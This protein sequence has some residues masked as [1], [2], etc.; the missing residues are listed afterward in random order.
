MKQF[1]ASLLLLTFLGSQ[2]MA[3]GKAIHIENLDWSF[4]GITGTYDREALQ[5]GFQVYR[6]LCA[7][8]HSMDLVAYRNLSA[9]GYSEDQ[10]K[11]IAAEDLIIDGPD[12][13]GEMFE[14]PGRPSDYFRNPY[15]NDNQ[16][17]YANNGALPPDLSL[18]AKARKGGPDYIY[19]LLTGYEETPADKKMNPGMHYNVSFSG[20]QI[21]MANPLSESILAYADPDTPQTIEQYAYD[22]AHFLQWT[23]EPSLEAQ[24]RVGI[25]VVLFLLALSIVMYFVKKRLWAKIKE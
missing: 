23:S 15:A 17:R 3:A 8:C 7:A 18:I 20:N 6:Q 11:T 10:I 16:A 2:A 9:L 4:E 5:R 12:D 13:E 19:A 21:A 14:R 1:L 25:K 24:K 22:V